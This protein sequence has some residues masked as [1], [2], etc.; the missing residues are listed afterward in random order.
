MF[1]TNYYFID[2]DWQFS[3]ALEEHKPPATQPHA[4]KRQKLHAIRQKLCK[5]IKVARLTQIM[6][7]SSLSR[8]T[9]IPKE[10]LVAFEA[11]TL[12]PSLEHVRRLNHALSENFLNQSM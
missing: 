7:I 2:Q 11:G 10:D 6:P 4:Y 5:S 9:G 12:H 8:A 1:R 3:E